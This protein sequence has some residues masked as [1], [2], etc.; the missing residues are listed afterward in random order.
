VPGRNKLQA[1]RGLGARGGVFF[2]AAAA[3]RTR[4]LPGPISG[5]VGRGVIRAQRVPRQPNPCSPASNGPLACLSACLGLEPL[6]EFQGVIGTP[7][8]HRNVLD[9]TLFTE[10]FETPRSAREGETERAK[11]QATQTQT[12]RT[13][14]VAE[15]EAERPRCESGVEFILNRIQNLEKEK[16]AREE[17]ER[18]RR[19]SSSVTTALW[20]SKQCIFIA[21]VLVH[22]TG[23]STPR[24][25]QHSWH[26]EARSCSVVCCLIRIFELKK[27]RKKSRKKG[28]HVVYTHMFNASR[29]SCA[30][31][32]LLRCCGVAVALLWCCVLATHPIGHSSTA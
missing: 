12:H 17:K 25:L 27:G 6:I 26:A 14:L 23:I 28:S 10:L 30:A 24:P 5:V 19:M 13:H 3:E 29:E 11:S 1:R 20:Q 15:V 32:A 9:D 16:W 7:F 2:V 4:P 18:R 21:V 22:T 8:W 31:V